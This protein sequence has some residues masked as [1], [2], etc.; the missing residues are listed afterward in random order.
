MDFEQVLNTKYTLPALEVEPWVSIRIVV[1]YNK[2]DGSTDYN[3]P[4]RILASYDLPRDLYMRKAWVVRWRAA[5]IQCQ[6]PKHKIDHCHTYY[7]K[8]SGSTDLHRM[9]S[10]FN[11]AKGQVTKVLN[12]MKF[13][14]EDCKNSLFDKVEDHPKYSLL[15]QKLEEKKSNLN[16]IYRELNSKMS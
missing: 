14:Q 5:R 7:D 2:P 13:L 1:R 9:I 8:K 10:K 16:T 12:A 11:S 3:R 4:G 15:V 6:Y